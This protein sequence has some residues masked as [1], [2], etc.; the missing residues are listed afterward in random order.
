MSIEAINGRE[1]TQ[2]RRQMPE[3]KMKS[4]WIFDLINAEFAAKIFRHLLQG[5]IVT[6]LLKKARHIGRAR[7]PKQQETTAKP[8]L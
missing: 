7:L 5:V 4:S 3:Q 1:S 6:T 2:A 8:C